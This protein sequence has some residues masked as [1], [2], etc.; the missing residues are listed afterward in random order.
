MRRLPV[1]FVL[2][3][4]ESMVG[5]PLESVQEGVEFILSNLRKDPYALE[6]VYVSVIAYA[7]IVRTLV[8]LTELFAFK[9]F[10]LPLGGGT[11]LGKALDHL[12][13]EIDRY[14]MKTTSEV[15][16]DWK[17]MVYL[18]T[19]G[20]PTDEYEQ[21]IERWNAKYANKATVV[22][23]GL[24]ADVDFS[25]LSKLTENTIS[26]DQI[27]QEYIK[28]LCKWITASVVSQSMS[29]GN[30]QQK[31]ELLPID[32]RYMRLAKEAL[33]I[34]KNKID[35]HCATFVGRCQKMNKPYIIKYIRNLQYKSPADLN[36]NIYNFKLD[37]CSA[38]SEEYFTWS[39]STAPNK[40]INTAE[41]DGFP[42]CP[43]CFSET[44]FAVCGCGN[45]MCYDGYR[46]SV[47]C[48]WCHRQISFSAS[49]EDFNLNRGQG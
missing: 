34:S 21:A 46:E 12:G 29:V 36:I 49:G 26:I 45:L 4:S 23:I 16:G 10:N 35:E 38:I 30:N 31:D 15:K 1:F 14:V 9:N 47:I 24:G 3:C 5:Q 17:P 11:H 41:L 40:Q 19:D 27:N 44:A 25:V 43:H 20:R 18:F 28:G 32:Q 2:D 6:T 8:P 7:G 37:T 39:D 33:S 13:Q 22:A 42:E 48:P